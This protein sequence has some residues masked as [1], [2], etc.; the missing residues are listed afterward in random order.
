MFLQC[1][2]ALNDGTI[3]A[4]RGG[5]GDSTGGGHHSSHSQQN[6]QHEDR[7]P[8]PPH[9]ASPPGTDRRRPAD[10][11]P[12]TATARSRRGHYNCRRR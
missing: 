10:I 9:S 4:L 12:D 1:C 11:D 3:A 7:D 6:C 5:F 8:P 2:H